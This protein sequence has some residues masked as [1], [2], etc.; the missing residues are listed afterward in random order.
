MSKICF[1]W[2]ACILSATSIFFLGHWTDNPLYPDWIAQA[3]N[4]IWG[5]VCGSAIAIMICSTLTAAK[6]WHHI[7]GQTVYS[8][9]GTIIVTFQKYTLLWRGRYNELIALN[10]EFQSY[11][12]KEHEV[13]LQIR[14]LDRRYKF[15]T[16]VAR[17]TTG[18]KPEMPGMLKDL[19]AERNAV[20]ADKLIL[21][22]LQEFASTNPEVIRELNNEYCEDQIHI[23]HISLCGFLEKQK[24][25]GIRTR[26]C[27][28]T[29]SE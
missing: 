13:P 28:F 2:G 12:L 8:I 19:L 4:A 14:S 6:I 11:K 25:K 24:L 27:R 10:G 26:N 5:I 21:R 3:W 16:L 29:C 18:G 7:P 23:L 20:S 17:F 9:E 1:I 15:L 22:L